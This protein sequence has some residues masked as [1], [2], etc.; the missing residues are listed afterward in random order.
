MAKRFSYLRR[1]VFSSRNKTFHQM[2]EFERQ[3]QLL[4]EEQAEEDALAEA[5]AEDLKINIVE[6]DKFVL[7]SGQE[8]EK[9]YILL[10]Y[11]SKPTFLN[12]SLFLNFI[13]LTPYGY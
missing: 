8:I 6:S 13:C 5:E 11:F 9:D 1:I 7:P 2:T 4:D 3:A 10:S 12:D